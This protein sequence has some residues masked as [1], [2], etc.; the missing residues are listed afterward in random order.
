MMGDANMNSMGATWCKRMAGSPSILFR[1]RALAAAAAL[2]V[3]TFV[4]SPAL[5]ATARRAESAPSMSGVHNANS[6]MSKEIV[7]PANGTLSFDYGVDSE[8]GYD[9]LEVFVDQVRVFVESGD[10]RAGTKSIPVSA[11]AH[12]IMFKYRK[13]VSVNRGLDAAWV[14]NV[15]AVAPGFY[16]AFSFRERIGPGPGG[17]SLGGS[18]GGWVVRGPE[19][20]RALRRPPAH[21]SLGNYGSS[22]VSGISKTVSWPSPG[23]VSFRYMVDSEAG[24]DGLRFL[25]DGQEVMFQSGSNSMGR[26]SHPVGAGSHTLE[27]R[28]VKNATTDAGLDTALVDDVE[29]GTLTGGRFAAF[30]FDGAAPLSV[31]YGWYA[32]GHG[33]GWSVGSD[34]AGDILLER[35]DFAG[36]L[37]DGSINPEGQPKEYFVPTWT[38]LHDQQDDLRPGLL[39]GSVSQTS[40]HLY[41]GFQLPSATP[42]LGGESGSLTVLLDGNARRTIAGGL[43]GTNGIFP[44]SEDRRIWI[45]YDFPPGN[46]VAALYTIQDVGAGAPAP[47]CFVE[48]SIRE[49]YPVVAAAREHPPEGPGS[50]GAI[51]FEIDIHLS[52]MASGLSDILT[53][54]RGGIGLVRVSNGSGGRQTLPAL[55]GAGPDVCDVS[56]YQP[57]LVFDPG[58]PAIAAF[59]MPLAAP[60]L[61]G[62]LLP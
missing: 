6:W 1:E 49:A 53:T 28:Y 52:S 31:P 41:L 36:V 17:W 34:P 30:G 46:P 32:F 23:F 25:V 8:A 56:T 26:F 29:C 47:D 45:A 12:V 20:R 14:D 58:Q 48:A 22:T 16:R 11:G 62:L 44:Q 38:T 3:A 13:D 2:L 60:R 37:V 15:L 35:H 55:P 24:A 43:G 50:S 57:F 33:G 59:A 54:G 42:E 40:G 51:Q 39:V 10:N 19:R 9:W 4:G 61:K 21:S 27:F 7:W 18:H 5:G